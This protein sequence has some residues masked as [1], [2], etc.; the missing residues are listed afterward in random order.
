MSELVDPLSTSTSL[1]NQVRAGE[2][3]AWNR[4]VNM[5]TPLILL[6]SKQHGMRGVD[7]EDI[8]QNVFV[9]VEKH[10]E[11]FGHNRSENSFRAWLWTITRSKIMDQLR[12]SKK[13]PKALGGEDF[14]K[15]EA[16]NERLAEERNA[17]ESA[18]DLKVLIA[19]TLEIIR[20]DFSQ[21]TWTAFWLTTAMGRRTSEVAQQ[22]GMTA[23][24]VCMCRARVLRRL[25]ETIRR[26]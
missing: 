8:V 7:T 20:K 3:L 16:A 13:N 12:F 10:I 1:L 24:A 25:R 9:A 22:L 5:Y 2:T 21:Q 23:A 19:G 18:H 4:L 14:G 15:F 26:E 17:S 6:W 11:E